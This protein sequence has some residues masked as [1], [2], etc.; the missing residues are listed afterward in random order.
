M[1]GIRRLQLR[2]LM[3]RKITSERFSTSKI[4]KDRKLII[5]SSLKYY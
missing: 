1:M 2:V 4:F 3:K 5:Q